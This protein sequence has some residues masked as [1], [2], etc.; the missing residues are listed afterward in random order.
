LQNWI[1]QRLK[2]IEGQQNAKALIAL[3]TLAFG[4]LIFAPKD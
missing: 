2:A 3:G 1:V 4:L